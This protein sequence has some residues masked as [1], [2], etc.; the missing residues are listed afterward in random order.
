[1]K[2]AIITLPL[3]T[4]YGGILQA[5]ALQTVLQR[6]GHDVQH[7]QPKVEFHPLHPAWKMPLVWSKRLLRKCFG[8]EWRLPV[9][10]HP[11]RWIRRYTDVFIYKYIE[12]RSLSDEEWNASLAKDYDVFIVGSDQ[13]WRPCYALPIERYFLSFLDD[14]CSNPRI[15][16]AASFGTE[17]CEFSSKQ[18]LS[19]RKLLQ[20][21]SFVS[22]REQSGVEICNQLFGVQ[23]SHLLDPTL[24]LSKADYL[25]LIQDQSPSKGNLMVYI[26]DETPD[27]QVLI[28]QIAAS[29]KLVPFNTNYSLGNRLGIPQLPLEN[30]LRGFVDA[31]L[32]ITDSFH[33]CVFAII[34]NKP[35]ICIGNNERGMSRFHSLLDLFGLQHCLLNEKQS[36]ETPDINWVQINVQLKKLRNQSLTCIKQVLE[37]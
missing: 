4:N 34:F 29:E 37:I 2:I 33:A 28:S 30:W 11:H 15:A 13:V 21:F 32:I 16:Y 3:H 6:M 12:M 19:C 9:F 18:I 26:L 31:K 22:V 5:Y 10:E 8:G 7:L 17:N 35:F 25:K 1:M 14:T 36:F 27:I 23:A 24:L 20:K